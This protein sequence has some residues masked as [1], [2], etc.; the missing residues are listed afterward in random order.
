[1]PC[2]ICGEGGVLGSPDAFA[3]PT[4]DSEL[5]C[6]DVKCPGRAWC[7]D[8]ELLSPYLPD[9]VCP[10]WVQD[11]GNTQANPFTNF[12]S[13]H[14]T[15]N[16]APRLTPRLTPR[17]TTPLPTLVP[18]VTSSPSFV[19][20]VTNNLDSIGQDFIISFLMSFIERKNLQ[21]GHHKQHDRT[22]HRQ[23]PRRNL[24]CERYYPCRQRFS[25]QSTTGRCVRLDRTS[26][27][28]IRVF[29]P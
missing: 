10:L 1:M 5:T 6:G 11:R 24:P 20:P 15:A 22:C 14:P 12:S 4:L 25:Y 2:S 16:S 18:T 13:T 27:N 23:I 9:P 29:L 7:L 28:S 19:A 3:F 26:C 17:P 8:G 21:H